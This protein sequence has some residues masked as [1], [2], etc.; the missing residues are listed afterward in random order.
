MKIN[1]SEKD[2]SKTD[3]FFNNIVH[4]NDKTQP[5]INKNKIMD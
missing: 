4:I 2:I 1:K 3:N 5:N